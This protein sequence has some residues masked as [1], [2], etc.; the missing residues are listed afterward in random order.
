MQRLRRTSVL[1][2]AVPLS[3]SLMTGT[4]WADKPSTD[5][6]KPQ[7][8]S[9]ADKN[10]T[11][12]NDTSASNPYKSTRDGSPSENGKGDGKAVGKPLAGEVGKADN[13]N[14]AGQAPSGADANAGYECDRNQGVGQT[15]PAHTGCT[16][17]VTPPTT[18][19]TPAPCVP[20]ASKPCTPP[21]CTPS[22]HKPCGPTP[23]PPVK[24]EPPVVK[25]P[26]K[27]PVVKQPPV[28]K[29]PVVKQPPVEVEVQGVKYKKPAVILRPT[30]APAAP[31]MLP[32]TGSELPM[33]VGFILV[34]S[35]VVVATASRKFAM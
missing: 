35:G 17:V 6:S 28:A 18:P 5:T 12:A 11:G 31:V 21:T 32:K 9:T 3:L 22:K 33:S 19:P 20:T 2:A 25:P 10:N 13:K 29:P 14:P 15:N 27:P 7:P 4:G 16:T 8:Y 23:K 26:V 30:P 34:G 1:A 24:P